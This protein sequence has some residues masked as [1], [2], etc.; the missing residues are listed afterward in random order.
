MSSFPILDL[1]A[2]MIFIFFMLSIISSSA[3]EIVMTSGK[4]RAKML[5]EWL[6]NIFNKDVTLH[7]GKVVPLG[8]ALMDHCSITALSGQGRSPAYIDAKNFAAALLE[9]VT[10][11]PANPKSVA[12]DIDGLITSI[13]NSSA[14]P[15]DLQR[16]LLGYAHEAKDTY[17]SVAIKAVGEI[18]LFKSKIENWFD[19]SMERVGGS[20]KRRYSRRFT[21]L[22]AVIITVLLNADAISI[23]KYLYSNPEARIKMAA[24]AYAAVDND[25]IKQQVNH[26]ILSRQVTADTSSSSDSL[27]KSLPDSSARKAITDTIIARIN[28][29]KMA[30]AILD[31]GIPLGWNRN[32]FNDSKGKFYFPLIFLKILGLAATILAIMMGAPF[33]FDLLNKVANL[34]G[35]GRKPEPAETK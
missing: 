22:S 23:G 2:G 9:K 24:Q 25:T 13:E 21:F 33:W 18:E 20:M 19:S 17:R 30:R 8:E 7:G 4:Y 27:L 12:A 1:V 31:D 16:I 29:I 26:I 10:Y 11:D 28:D 34:R 3:V 14:L 32:V 35:S 15:S 5:E 6:R